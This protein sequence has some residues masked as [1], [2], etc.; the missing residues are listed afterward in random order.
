MKKLVLIVLVFLCGPKVAQSQ[1]LSGFATKWSD[2][3][4]AW[5]VFGLDTIAQDSTEIITEEVLMGTLQQRWI[6]VRED[7]TEWDFSINDHDGTI[8]IKWKNDPSQWE[9]RTYEGEIITMKTI[10]RDDYTAWRIT[11]NT[12]SYD[13]KSRYTTDLGEWVAKDDDDHKFAIT[14][15]GF[16][17]PRDW[18]ITDEFAPEVRAEMK[19]AMIFIVLYHASP[20]R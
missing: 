20:R 8:K 13:L 2:S 7:W 6:D 10:W 1:Q 18:V 17:D 16:N 19:L 4:M 14:V 5:E 11:D 9:L 12:N 15:A 3:F